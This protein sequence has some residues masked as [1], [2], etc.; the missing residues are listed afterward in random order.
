M[1]IKRTSRR[2]EKFKKRLVPLT[3]LGLVILGIIYQQIAVYYNA[4]HLGRMGRLIDIDGVNMHLYES[5]NSDIPIVFTA[6]IGSNVPY[7]DLYPIHSALSE[8][9]EVMIY[10]RPGYG[11]SDYTSKSRDIDQICEEIHT[12]LHADDIPGDEDTYLEPFVYVAQGMGALEAIRYAQLYPEDVAGIVFIE[13]TSP[14]FAADYNNI[15]IIESFMVNGLRNTG[16]LRL[17]SN[18]SFVRRTLNDNNELTDNLRELNKGIGLEKNWNRNVI[19]EK[20]KFPANGQTILDAINAGQTLGDIPV[21]VITSESNVYSNWSRTQKSLLS[22]STDSS[23]TFVKDSTT[24]INESDVPTI[25][26]TIDDLITHIHELRD[27]Y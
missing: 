6:N 13:G 3:I 7:V 20:L 23:Q 10:D 19:A 12:L 18:S 27:D 4:S 2:K 24:I 1:R 5:G 17:M 26:S 16:L 21:R 15:M 14:S 9:N 25:V 22:L 8:N 11:W